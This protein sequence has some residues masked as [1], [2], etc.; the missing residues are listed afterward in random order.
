[1]LSGGGA[2]G[3]AHVGVL[4]VIEEKRIPVDFIAGTSMGAIIGGLYSS[5]LSPEEIERI[6]A[7]TD[8]NDLFSDRP[9][10]QHL[11]FR[12]KQE[13]L[14]S[15]WKI[16]MGWKK[17]LTF[18][19]SLIAGD[20]LMFYLRKVTLH[21]HGVSSFDDL[22]IPFR[23]VATDVESGD[24]VVLSKGDLPEALRASMAIPG[25]FGAEEIEGRLLVDGFLSQNLPVSVARDRG[26]SV[27]IAVDVGSLLSKRTELT[28][29]FAFANQT[30]TMM[31]RK[32]TKE[33]L[34]LLRQGDI[35]IEP[36]LG[37]MAGLDFS[38]TAD[39]VTLGAEAA[40]KALA[41]FSGALSEQEYAAWRA[42]KR[43]PLTETLK[44]DSVRVEGSGRVPNR[45]VEKRAGVGFADGE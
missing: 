32:N 39:A 45:T 25:V 18:P 6:L 13:D 2:R 17:G 14:D 36:K 22:P 1:M 24:A 43:R 8:W 12:R 23:A 38:R 10:R 33:Q 34:A 35:L 4:K 30:L 20:K 21:T 15:L 19:A 31:S 42:A 44:I 41:N 29:V 28:S 40:Q 9:S 27:I 16:E 11:S 7:S 37:E 26:V 5:G 3:S